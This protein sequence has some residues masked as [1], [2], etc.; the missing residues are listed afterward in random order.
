[1]KC[2]LPTRE[3]Q[4]KALRYGRRVNCPNGRELQGKAL[5]CGVIKML[6]LFPLSCERS[7]EIVDNHSFKRVAHR[8]ISA[9]NPQ[10]TEQIADKFHSFYHFCG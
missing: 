6:P 5:R 9:C 7:V 2:V 4:G 10:K 1:V 8:K 3:L